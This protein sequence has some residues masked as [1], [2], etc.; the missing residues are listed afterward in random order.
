MTAGLKRVT[1]RMNADERARV[2]AMADAA[3]MRLAE[4]G[5]VG[6][7]TP[8]TPDGILEE[9]ARISERVLLLDIDLSV[10]HRRKVELYQAGLA[11]DPPMGKTDLGRPSGISGEAVIGAIKRAEPD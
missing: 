1:A 5:V 10:L 11:L 6:S 3:A 8:D 4:E 2:E 7:G 9:L